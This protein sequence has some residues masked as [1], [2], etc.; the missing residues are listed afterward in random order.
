MLGHLHVAQCEI[1]VSKIRGTLLG[2]PISR[3]I[4]FWVYI[5]V[6]LFWETTSL[7]NM[8]LHVDP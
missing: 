4:L 2:V 1:G 3:I 5:G 7:P 6:S 8:D